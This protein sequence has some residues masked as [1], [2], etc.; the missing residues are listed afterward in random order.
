MQPCHLTMI[1]ATMIAQPHR[2][3]GEIPT[4][5]HLINN[6]YTFTYCTI[7]SSSHYIDLHRC[8]TRH[9]T[10]INEQH[11]RSSGLEPNM[12]SH[13]LILLGRQCRTSHANFN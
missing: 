11:R 4:K 3:L 2:S 5:P 8:W 12:C 6:N 7:L 10:Q 9:S 1:L 13:L